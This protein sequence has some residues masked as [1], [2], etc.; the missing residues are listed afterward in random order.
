MSIRLHVVYGGF[1]DA[2]AELSSCSSN[3]VVYQTSIFSLA[4]CGK[5][6]LTPA[7]SRRL[8]KLE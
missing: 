4:L 6:L 3:S 1:C 2:V 5:R 7:L 8:Q